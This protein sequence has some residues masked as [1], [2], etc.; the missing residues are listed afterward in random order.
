MRIIV[1][2]LD[3]DCPDGST[4][5]DLVRALGLSPR[6]VVAEHNRNIVKNEDLPRVLL[7]EGDSLELVRLVGGG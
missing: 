2:G 4:L 3:H 6:A 1:N 7:H 5:L